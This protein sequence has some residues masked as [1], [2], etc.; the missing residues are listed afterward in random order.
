ML[1][2]LILIVAVAVGMFIVV[3]IQNASMQKLLQ[4]GDYTAQEKKRS[5]LKEIVGFSY[6]GF[7]TALF[8]TVSLLCEKWEY[9]WLIFGIGGILFP[10]LMSACNIIA[11]RYKK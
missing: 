1:A 6:W 9:T 8:L 4:E 11:D 5:T 10:I 7:L 3:G 2:L